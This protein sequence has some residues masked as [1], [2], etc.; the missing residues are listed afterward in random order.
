MTDALVD[1]CLPA[2][3]PPD[4][5]SIVE[6]WLR[7]PGDPVRIH[8]PLLEINTDKAVVE[9]AAPASGVLAEILKRANDPVRTGDILGR[10][11][12]RDRTAAERPAKTPSAAAKREGPRESRGG[13]VADLSPAVRQLIRQHDLDPARIAGSGR[14]G[15]ITVQDVERYL[16]KRAV[17]AAPLAGQRIPHSPLRRR[18]A[19]HMVQSALHTAPHVTA[20][21]EADLTR[22]V[23]DRARRRAEFEQHGLKLT[24]TAYFVAAV[25]QALR[26]VPEV[27]SR[28]H[29]DALEILADCNIGIATAA[30]GGLLVPVIHR[31]QEL[32]LPGIA[33]RLGELTERAR[34]GKLEPHELQNG[35]FTITNHGTSGSLLAT[36]IIHQPQSAILGIGKIE[37]RV[38]VLEEAGRDLLAICPCAYVTLTIDH[39]ALDGFQANR[40]LTAFVEALTTAP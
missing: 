23:A 7:Q 3:H 19:Q 28:W 24:Y 33:R 25:V 21:F 31:A 16:Q 38:V 1:I 30:P 13:S 34:A 4:A 2:D 26:A 29:E 27:N 35:T 39:R 17:P 40:F 32:D 5:E 36:P 10:I 14:G 12:A 18:I 22:I 8:E 37:K 20:V 9:I 15:R 6:R 11:A